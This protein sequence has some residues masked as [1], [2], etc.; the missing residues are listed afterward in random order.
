[1]SRAWG[2]F[3]STGRRWGDAWLGQER[4]PGPDRGVDTA[5]PPLRRFIW[6]LSTCVHFGTRK[7]L[8]VANC[9][10]DRWTRYSTIVHRIGECSFTHLKCAWPID[11]SFKLIRVLSL[12]HSSIVARRHITCHTH[13]GIL[14]RH[15]F[16]LVSSPRTSLSKTISG[17]HP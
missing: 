11:P 3:M 6:F 4:V 8:Q 13:D 7:P 5:Q 12:R 9:I 15:A 10:V 2:W 17:R 14:Y 16:R 1:M